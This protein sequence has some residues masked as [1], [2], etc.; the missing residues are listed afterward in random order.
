MME[1]LLPQRLNLGN[2][3]GIVAP[4]GFIHEPGSLD[5]AT[6]YLQEQGY[7]V[8]EMPHCRNRWEYFAGTDFER[9]QDL[10]QVFARPDIHLV[11]A[12]RGGYGL[13]RLLPSLDLEAMAASRKM[14]VGFSD[15][16]ALHLALLAK[17]GLVSFAGPMA[18]PDFGH[19]QRSEWHPVHFEQMLQTTTH[20]TMP[21]KMPFTACDG[22]NGE[23]LRRQV[24]TGIDGTLW[25]GNLS[26]MA[27]LVGTPYMPKIEGGILFLEDVNEEPYVIERM[28]MQL[29]HAGILERQ[30]A[31]LLGQFNRCEPTSRSATNYTLTRVVDFLK[32]WLQIPV[33]Q[34]LPFGHVRDKITLPVGGQALVTLRDERHYQITFSHY[35][36]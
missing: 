32:G 19:H 30:R 6:L 33:L 8:A 27:H 16:T 15:I 9:A 20:T 1:I 31:V 5:I 2:T 4:S 11:M 23:L 17:T 18:C 34:N 21:I 26:V 14:L 25:G 12:A 13:T 7:G 22:E 3:M 24:G 36:H 10:H 35:N 28:L 29:I